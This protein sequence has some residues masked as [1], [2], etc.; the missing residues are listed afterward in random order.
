MLEH[1]Q[2]LPAGASA[3]SRSSLIIQQTQPKKKGER[4]V[5]EIKN[6]KKKL[7]KNQDKREKYE[8]TQN[9]YMKWI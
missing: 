1:P 2:D 7:L 5:E 4:K 9:V 6:A 8:K 3:C